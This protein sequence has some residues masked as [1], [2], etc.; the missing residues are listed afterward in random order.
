MELKKG[1]SSRQIRISVLQL[2]IFVSVSQLA[3]H[4]R[5][6][7]FILLILLDRALASIL[8]LRFLDGYNLNPLI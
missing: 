7:T 6:A 3:A 5:V 4:T 1:V 2:P 8:I